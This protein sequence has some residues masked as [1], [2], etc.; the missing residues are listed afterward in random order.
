MRTQM[1]RRFKRH[2]AFLTGFWVIVCA[3]E[4]LLFQMSGQNML[5]ECRVLAE[6]LVTGRIPGAPVFVLAIMCSQMPSKPRACHEAL[7]TTRTITDIVSDSGMGAFDV[8]IQVRG[9][10][11]GLVTA[12]E[13]AAK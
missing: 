10:K 1:A 9:S 7:S 12:V 6:G 4:G 13:S 5:L 11:E 8:V 2:Y 3:L